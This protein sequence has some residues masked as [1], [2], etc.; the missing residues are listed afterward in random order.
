[1]AR[2]AVV[3]AA[4]LAIVAMMVFPLPA[5]LIDLL[6]VLNISFSLLLLIRT[7]YLSQPEKFTLLPTILLLSTLFRLA[8]NISTTRQILSGAAAPEVVTTFG[9]FVVRGNM[10]VGAVIFAIITIV[11]FLVV[12]KG[13]ERVAEV[14]ARFTLDALPGKQMSIDADIRSGLLGLAEARTKRSELAMESRLYGAL[15]G[16]MKF[17]KGD[18][19]AGVIIAL[20]NMAGGLVVGVLQQQMALSEAAHRYVLLSIGDGLASQIPALLT[21]VSAGIAVTRVESSEGGSI[22]RELYAQIL[23][24]PA[25]LVASSIV[26]LLL[27]AVPG[28]PALPLLLL[29]AALLLCGRSAGLKR[30]NETREPD[31]G[32]AAAVRGFA[33]ATSLETAVRLR[34]EGILVPKL[35]S[36]RKV[37]FEEW[38]VL[39]PD[40]QLLIEK[41]QKGEKAALDFRAQKLLET[42][43]ERSASLSSDLH[44]AVDKFARENLLEFVDD[45][46][47]RTLLEMHR[48]TAEDLINS[49]IPELIPLTTLTML[50]RELLWEA[51]SVRDLPAILQAIAEYKVTGTVRAGNDGSLCLTGAMLP[52]LKSLS[53][54]KRNTE[55][56]ELLIAVRTAL[57][58]VITMQVTAGRAEIS[59]W[60]LAAED[61]LLLAKAAFAGL[62]LPP[63]IGIRLI[64]ALTEKSRAHE[65]PLVLL[66]GRYARHQAAQIVKPVL[67]D[68]HVLSPEEIRKE[69]RVVILGELSLNMNQDA[70]EEEQIELKAKHCAVLPRKERLA[71]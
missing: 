70:D 44:R 53:A 4:V 12:A 40:V 31:A 2:D 48:G 19:I 13:A 6:L 11:Q 55:L 30:K 71:A 26:L 68:V 37:I 61:E 36:T 20:I 41:E 39:I 47:S 28:F 49:V 54:E 24:E 59:A 32:P 23:S 50:L 33:L 5:A 14:A 51:V 8:L 21:A 3:P 29:A 16:A 46:Q 34:D 15:D 9:N 35:Q 56:E 1:M 38:G 57:K 63:A 64:D 66:S 27:A 7:I 65:G 43:G 67:G 17:V 25:A 58:R 18:A 10:A 22:G 42:C 69:V 52:S 60:V 45:S 62:P